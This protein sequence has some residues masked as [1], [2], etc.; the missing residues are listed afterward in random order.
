MGKA[1]WLSVALGCVAAV[2]CA[3]ATTLV[4]RR[5]VA[6]YRW[7]RAVAVVRGFEEDCATPTERLQRIVNSLSIEM[8]AGLAS[9]GAS[10]VRMLLTCVDALPDG[11]EEGI[12]Y[13]VDLGGTSFRVMK[14]EL[15]SGSMVINK[16]VEHQPI[17]EDLTKGTS[18]DLFNLIA[19]ALKNFIEREGGGDEGRALGFT[20]SFPVRQVSI[21]SGSLIR[22][23]KEFSIEEAVG[24][25]VAQC[26]NE[27]LVRNGLNLQVTALVNNAVGT[28]AMG[29]Y[30]DEDTVAA[31]II[32]AGT[33]ASYIERNAAIPKSQGLLT[34]SDI[35]VVNVEWGSF[36]SPQIPL[37][38]YD[39]CS[40]EAERNHYDQ[41]F[42]KMISG[43][44]LGEIARLVFQRMAQESDL[45]G[46]FVNCLSTP[47]ILSTPSLAAI[48]EDDSPDLRV[49]GKVLEEH[50]KIQDVPLKTRRLVVR[51]C[52]IVTRRAARL[53]AAGIVAILQKIGRD[54]T[55]CGTTFVRKIR[56]EAKRSVVAIEGGL[57]QG[58]SVFR[59]YLNEAV[60]EILGDE[61]APTVSLRV[62]EEGSG[63]GAALLAASYSSTRKNFV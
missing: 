2:T 63:I 40:S 56:G 41:A 25:D 24:R 23:T 31:V 57:Y 29:H 34:N 19:L 8:F 7:S 13:S 47:F 5:A 32:G 42:E 6:R 46:S 43:V 62:M 11:S 54:G 36:R 50:L 45:F 35:T 38:P 20:F 33:N 3:V 58:Y 10:K 37:T 49:V 1:Q 22:W 52:D 55:L 18:E 51:I 15:G 39:I 60:D 12:Y 9:E 44:Y 27:A 14:L 53:A 30:Y 17:P 16:K 4:A 59:E 26:L 48:R 21:S 61:L 28:L